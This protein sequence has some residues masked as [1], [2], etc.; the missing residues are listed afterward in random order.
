[1]DYYID[2]AEQDPKV[3]AELDKITR[4]NIDPAK[5]TFIDPA[6]GSGHILVYAFDLL[7]E[8]YLEAGYPE[9]SIPSMILEKNLYGLD[10]D[11][12][13][14]QLASFALLMR[15]RSKDPQI[16]SKGILP[17]VIAIEE[18]NNISHE[19]ID[20]LVSPE[21]N[22]HEQRSSDMNL[23]VCSRYSKMQRSMARSS[24]SQRWILSG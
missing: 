3:M 5:I 14:V 19:M 7:Y 24:A 16:L 8:M 18:S 23:S 22:H 4:K 20:L 17:N 1:M 9:T 10:I 15:A 11:E 2:E 6:C 21:A 13:A 12:R